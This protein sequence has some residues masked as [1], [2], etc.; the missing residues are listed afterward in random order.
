[1][2]TQINSL[3][4]TPF[5][6]SKFLNFLQKDNSK[7]FQENILK[8]TNSKEPFLGFCYDASVKFLHYSDK[9]LEQDYINIYNKYFDD[10]KTNDTMIPRE[11]G[12]LTMASIS[13]YK[14]YTEKKH[15]IKQGNQLLK[16][17]FDIQKLRYNSTNNYN[18]SLHIPLSS[19]IFKEK[20]LLKLIELALD[21]NIKWCVD[22]EYRM[23]KI[24]IAP[25]ISDNIKCT[26]KIYSLNSSKISSPDTDTQ[27]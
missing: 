25:L 14:K 26:K 12:N 4:K 9:G 3:N 7:F 10:V 5:T 17:I 11:R 24:T 8:I 18:L 6:Q 22:K 2:P 23:F 27:K 21:E 1:M 20:S 16:E 19:P 13:D 15:I